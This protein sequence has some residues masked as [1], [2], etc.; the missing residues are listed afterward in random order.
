MSSNSPRSTGLG[1]TTTAESLNGRLAMI[2][3]TLAIII[4]VITG[5]G[6]LQFLQL[7]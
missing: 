4:E 7:N 3:F 5:K 2:G 6:V 1:F